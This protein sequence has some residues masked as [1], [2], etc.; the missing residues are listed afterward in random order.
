MSLA[1]ILVSVY[2]RKDHLAR[3]IDSLK[4]NPLSVESLLYI[5][6][7]AAGSPDDL[8]KVES[9]RT[10]I[11]R[12]TGFAQVR[13]IL[14]ATNLGSF[15]IN[16]TVG[17]VLAEHG[18]VIL[19]EDDNIVS[20][21]FLAYMNDALEFYDGDPSVFSI[22]GYNYPVQIPKSY[23]YTVYKWQGYGGWGV[24]YWRN[25]Y[26]TIEW[27]YPSLAEIAKGE[28]LRCELD[29]IAEHLCRQ[30]TYDI[31]NNRKTGDTMLIY[32]MYKRGLYSI[33]PVISKVRN[34][35]HDGTGEH[36]G[37]TDRYIRQPI[38][39]GLSYQFVRDLQ[40][41]EQINR[42]LWHHFRT[43]FK[44]KVIMALS[45]YVPEPQKK[46]LKQRLFARG[47]VGAAQYTRQG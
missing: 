41:D 6:S 7:D 30:M 27:A 4:N 12:I 21:N 46:W 35:G 25:R 20:P 16:N 11:D 18:R 10:Y 39:P 29:R 44:A 43:P 1:P 33:F 14:R 3:C 37:V 42:V 22:T 5:V 31:T 32:F 40:P 47:T 36:G 8:Q 17:D 15:S 9:V 38:D 13:P 28:P 2:T 34:T 19:L 26:E 45:R 24:G 23:P